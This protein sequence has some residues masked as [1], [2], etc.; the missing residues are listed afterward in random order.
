MAGGLFKNYPFELNIK[1]VI[2]STIIIAL[3]FYQPPEMSLIW[4]CFIAVLLFVI[5]YVA[6]AWYD[7]KFECTKLALKRG[8]KGGITTMLKP[9]PHVESQTD[10][11]K[12]TTDEKQLTMSLINIYH[13]FIVTPLLLYVGIN[14]LIGGKTEMS[15]Q[16]SVVILIANF[17]FAI[18]YHIVRV[19]RK[20]NGVSLGHVLGGIISIVFLL[21]KQRPIPFY[22][23][24]IFVAFYALF[25]HGYKLMISSHALNTD[26][27]VD[28]NNQK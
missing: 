13:I 17:A 11:S 23:F 9:Q 20:F 10:P 16:T 28:I 22:Y 8:S 12:V 2:F 3:F 19:L 25:T 5:A 15:M 4:K 24:L 1:C 18:L 27:E 6:M 26:I 7:Y 14:G 21:M